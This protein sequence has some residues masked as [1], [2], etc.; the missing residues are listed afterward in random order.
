MPDTA[1]NIAQLITIITAIG[2]ILSFL[3]NAWLSRHRPK[4]DEAEAA[5]LITQAASD[6]VED[7]TDR[8]DEL[9]G[10]I[11]ELEVSDVKLVAEVSGLRV[12][13]RELEQENHRLAEE[14]RVLK[15][16]L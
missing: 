2:A 5:S 4:V 16:G 6:L 14:N 9:K 11:D 3:G 13:V 8:I 10:R 12:R 15:G 1:P 7:L